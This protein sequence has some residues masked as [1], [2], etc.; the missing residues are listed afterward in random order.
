MH[1]IVN[2]FECNYNAWITGWHIV[3][4]YFL[5]PQ[6]QETWQKSLHFTILHLRVKTANLVGG[7]MYFH[8]AVNHSDTNQSQAS[9]SSCMR[10]TVDSTLLRVLRFF[11]VQHE[12]QFM[13]NIQKWSILHTLIIFLAALIRFIRFCFVFSFFT[14]FISD[15]IIKTLSFKMN[16][17]KAQLMGLMSIPSLDKPIK[18]FLWNFVLHTTCTHKNVLILFNQHTAGF[19]WGIV[20]GHGAINPKSSFGES[21]LRDAH[22][23][24]LL[25]MLVAMF[26]ILPE[27][28]VCRW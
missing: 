20:S 1:L 23:S 4:F 17:I 16:E 22:R 5:P 14:S 10:K 3:I 13:T 28:W 12:Q 11:V 25:A 21:I 19:K 15:A 27:D 6:T 26:A 8:S 18:S 24:F 7:M 9:V 2:S